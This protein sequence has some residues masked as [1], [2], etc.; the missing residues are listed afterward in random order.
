MCRGLV[1]IAF[2]PFST[3]TP[4]VI[5][6]QQQQQQQQ[7]KKTLESYNNTNTDNNLIIKMGCASSTQVVTDPHTGQQK[8]KTKLGGAYP[9]N[10]RQANKPYA[11]PAS[12]FSGG[13]ATAHFVN[14]GGGN[15]LV[16][17]Q[18]NG[19][20]QP[21][22][23]ASPLG[24]GGKQPEYIQV[25]LPDGVYAGQKIQVAAPDGRLN[26]I[27]IPT[28]F[29]PGSTFTV[30]FADGPPPSKAEEGPSS[31]SSSSYTPTYT[32]YVTNNN[33]NN[34]NNRNNTNN[35]ST[36]P[37]ATAQATATTTGPSQDDGFASGFNN[38]NHVPHAGNATPVL[39]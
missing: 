29:G 26:E 15:A 34:N 30:E 6:L 36:A 37:P 7:Q 23:G 8:Q 38:P 22:V 9:G 27:I 16:L 18:D 5:I 4:R 13:Q 21:Q 33:S 2:L 24:G 25:T 10:R 39:Y 28:G 1:S 14:Y 31:S 17:K 3:E 32:P 11:P 19:T 35:Y 20:A 12:Q